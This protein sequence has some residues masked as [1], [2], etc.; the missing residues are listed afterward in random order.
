MWMLLSLC[1]IIMEKDSRVRLVNSSNV[2]RTNSFSNEERKNAREWFLAAVG[3]ALIPPS[4]IEKTWTAAMDEKTPTHRSS[5]KFNDYMVSNYVDS[6]SSLYSIESWNVHDVLVKDLPRT[7]NHVEG[8]NSQLGSLFPIHPHIF[9]FIECV[10]D[11]HLFQCHL[12]EQSR[13]HPIK[14][15]QITEDVNALLRVLLNNHGIG[16]IT[17]LERAILCGRTVKIRLVK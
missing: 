8:Y 13:V 14:R 11:E 7:N 4:L 3:L 15:K 6:T 16:E 2:H 5:V 17:D 12:A 9:R 10:P 1:A